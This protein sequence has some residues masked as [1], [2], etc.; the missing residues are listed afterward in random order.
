MRGVCKPSLD[1]FSPS[2]DCNSDYVITETQNSIENEEF[3][4]KSR[5]ITILTN[6][7]C[8]QT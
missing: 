8:E 3:D 5:L 7:D 2:E 6:Q 1:E 4:N